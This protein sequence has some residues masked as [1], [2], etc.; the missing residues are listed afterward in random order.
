MNRLSFK[1]LAVF[2]LIFT[3]SISVCQGQ[4]RGDRAPKPQKKG[5]FGLFS[6][7]KSGSK[8]GKPKSVKQIQK[9]QA[10]KKKKSDEEYAKSIRESQKRTIKIQTPAV[11]ERMKQ[12]KKEVT[13]REKEKKKKTTSST[14]KGAKKYKK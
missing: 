11:Q 4:S 12:N 5:I 9:E 13:S 10:K 8:L 6:G 1:K 14:R 7:K 3:F 2:A